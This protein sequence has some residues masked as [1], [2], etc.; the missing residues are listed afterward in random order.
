MEL[1]LQTR[2]IT[3]THTPHTYIPPPTRSQAVLQAF[4]NASLSLSLITH[5]GTLHASCGA[6]YC[7]RSCRG[8]VC[9]FVGLLPR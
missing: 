3:H 2:S 8:F 9:V 5:I 7:N 1:M 6:A 4:L